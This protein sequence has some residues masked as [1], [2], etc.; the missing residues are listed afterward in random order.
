MLEKLRRRDEL[1]D[2]AVT[3]LEGNFHGDRLETA[4]AFL[5][6]YCLA[7]QFGLAPAG[8]GLARLCKD[9]GLKPVERDF[10]IGILD[11]VFSKGPAK[12]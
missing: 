6:D 5:G 2:R 8:E 3:Q 4:K 12:Q 11:D 1:V 7:A 10:I 9:Y